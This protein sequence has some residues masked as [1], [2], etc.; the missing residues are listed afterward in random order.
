MKIWSILPSAKLNVCTSV[1]P[2]AAANDDA[3][4]RHP[5]RSVQAATVIEAG[6]GLS[7]MIIAGGS[8]PNGRVRN[9]MRIN[10]AMKHVFMVF[11]LELALLGGLEA[12]ET[13]YTT[14]FPATENPISE[15]GRWINGKTIGL[16]WKNVRTT[17]GRAF[18]TQTA[19]DG[20]DDSTALLTGTWGSNQTVQATV[21]MVNQQV[22]DNTISEVELRLRNSITANRNTGYEV[23]FRCR[24]N[25][26]QYV[27][28][29]RWNGPLGDFTYVQRAGGPGLFNGDVV[30]A[31]I[32][33]NVLTAFINGNQVIQGT[34]STY[35]SGSPGIGFYQRG[36]TA[37]NADFGFTNFTASRGLTP[38]SAPPN[39]R[40]VPQ[41]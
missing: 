25:G 6:S 14:N 23:N 11:F 21:F 19:S 41:P 5:M 20:Y 10:R 4:V 27:E 32:V 26:S 8:A 9:A 37:L 28:I 12:Q 1:S 38:Q 3:T 7:R 17:P 34:N 13:S 36:N 29:M 24:H 2:V 35:S 39:L 15:G 22:G 18:G 40:I 33:G 30:K 31:T 16:D